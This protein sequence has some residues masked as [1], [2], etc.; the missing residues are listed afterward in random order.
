MSM[1]ETY[2][3]RGPWAR[4]VES[5]GAAVE[6]AGPGEWLAQAGPALHG[7]FCTRGGAPW[8]FLATDPADVDGWLIAAVES[9]GGAA[10]R[11][12]GAP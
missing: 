11:L 2:T 6:A 12:W 4:D 8:G 5:I 3:E 7:W 10:K 9:R 1:F